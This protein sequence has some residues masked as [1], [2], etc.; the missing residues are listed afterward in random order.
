MEQTHKTNKQNKPMV[1][2][3]T[4]I[5]TTEPFIFVRKGN[6]FR[7]FVIHNSHI[8]LVSYPEMLIKHIINIYFIIMKQ[9]I[10]VLKKKSS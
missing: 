2:D 1:C 7:D 3:I 10:N 5:T 8:I 4:R 9:L 6:Y